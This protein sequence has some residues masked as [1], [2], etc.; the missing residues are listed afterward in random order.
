[1]KKLDLGDLFTRDEFREYVEN[2]WFIDTDGEG[3]YSNENGDWTGKWLSPSSFT[4]DEVKNKNMEWNKM[5]FRLESVRE[6][7]MGGVAMKASF[8]TTVLR[9]IIT[10]CLFTSV[11]Y[12]VHSEAITQHSAAE[13]ERDISYS[14]AEIIDINYQISAALIIAEPLSD[15]LYVSIRVS[16]VNPVNYAF[17]SFH[18]YINDQ[19][20]QKIPFIG[21][22]SAEQNTLSFAAVF[23]LS[24][25]RID[26]L[27]LIPVI[28]TH[29]ATSFETE[30][31]LSGSISFAD[32]ESSK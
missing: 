16:Y 29:N 6:N 5:L 28:E 30:E 9:L 10:I 19:A 13:V 2:G 27:E 8:T 22:S 24:E 32:F 23:H 26:S 20:A 11:P 21:Q 14:Y 12:V 17:N 25:S 1:M 31:L 15:C 18:I 7:W 3:Q 4:L